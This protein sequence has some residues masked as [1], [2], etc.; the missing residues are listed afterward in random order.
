[1][2][3]PDFWQ[4]DALPARILAPFG[5]ITRALTARRVAR[6]GFDCGV[7]VICAG[8]AGTG[9]AGKTILARHLLALHAARGETPFAL[10]R[11]HGGALRHPVRVDPAQHDAAAVGDEALLLAASAPTIVARDRAAGAR[12]AV[13]Q[14]ATV[15]VMDDGLQNPD[16]VK[17]AAFLVIDGG[18]GFG[19]GRLLPAGPLREP[20]AAAAARCV[21][22]I[23]IGSDRTG[24]RTALPPGLPV[25]QATLVTDAARLAG[26]RV[27]GFA[28][29]GRPAKFFDSLRD[30][31][32]DLVASRAF[33]DH[34]A[35]RPSDLDRLAAAAESHGATLATTE[36]D[37]VKLPPDFRA[38]CAII[39]AGL[40]FEDP[41][42]LDRLQP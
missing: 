29:I 39:S 23:L 19:N 20:V 22:A 12:L 38:R 30:A 35:Y 28:G 1:M 17:T 34:H 41:A 3:A 36:K 37:A 4:T 25:L 18:A 40:A 11:G 6:P 24:A 10:T 32:A 13:E 16:P 15:I 33:P 9:G 26:R 7:D 14:G 31:G 5:A 2:R 21:A 8:N 27:F 42:A